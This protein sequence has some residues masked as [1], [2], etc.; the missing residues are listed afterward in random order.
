[1]SPR[2]RRLMVLLAVAFV[3]SV[4]GLVGRMIWDGL[5]AIEARNE[6]RRDALRALDT[7]RRVAA[8][9][10]IDEPE[11]KIPKEPVDLPAYLE[12]IAKEV[13]IEIPN[14]APQPQ[15][16]RGAY[17]EIAVAIDLRNLTVQQLADFLE[18]V[19]S[20]NRAV[21]VTQLQIERSFREEGKLRKASMTVAT[22]APRRAKDKKSGGDAADGE[23]T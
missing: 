13:G 19:E 9:G 21:V 15:V 23:G 18:K 4:F 6:L 11:V 16:A 17:D 10:G 2:E 22:Y 3:V 14:Y 7:Y 1:M 5:D 20:R 12:D 8:E